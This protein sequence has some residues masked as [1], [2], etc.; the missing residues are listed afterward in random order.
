MFLRTLTEIV[1]SLLVAQNVGAHLRLV[2]DYARGDDLGHASRRLGHASHLALS[3]DASARGAPA[4]PARQR[5]A[6]GPIVGTAA[7]TVP[8]PH[9]TPASGEA[10]GP[11]G[12][13]ESP[14]LIRKLISP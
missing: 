9:P 1:A 8:R 12:L 3:L 13:T 7:A 10:R 4:Q 14:K 11:R 5:A 6:R 2:S